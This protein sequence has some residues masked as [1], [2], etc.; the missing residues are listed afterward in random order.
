MHS[1]T[2]RLQ[3][4]GKDVTDES[5]INANRPDQSEEQLWPGVFLGSYQDLRIP[6]W[7][8]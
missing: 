2:N 4:S 3:F 6:L 1:V 7:V 5:Q 8:E